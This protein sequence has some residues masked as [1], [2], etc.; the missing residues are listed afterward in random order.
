M[1][2]LGLAAAASLSLGLALAASPRPAAAQGSRD[3]VFTYDDD[4]LV[5]RVSGLKPGEVDERQVDEVAN[6]QVS[7]MVHDRLQADALFDAEP[8]DSGWADTTRSQLER[9]LG[10][11]LPGVS[12]VEV[13]CRSSTCRLVLDHSG[14]RTVADHEAVMTTVEQSIRALI[15]ADPGNFERIFLIAGQYKEPGDPYIKVFLR[16]AHDAAASASQRPG[17]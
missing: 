7:T 4:H 16:R 13:E 10:H 3:F 8:V 11:G 6:V 15:D 5:L 9:R 2:L 14:G 1:R 17:G 12:A